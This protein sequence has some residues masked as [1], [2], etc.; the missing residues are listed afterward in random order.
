MGTTFMNVARKNNDFRGEIFFFFKIFFRPDFVKEICLR[1][2]TVS[3]LISIYFSQSPAFSPAKVFLFT[4]SLA[5]QLHWVLVE[6]VLTVE[7][8]IVVSIIKKTFPSLH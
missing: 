5:F 7:A 3:K 2:E 8:K 4:V 6:N 1:I